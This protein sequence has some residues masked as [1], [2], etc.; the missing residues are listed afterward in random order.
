VS[1]KKT[2]GVFNDV[3]CGEVQE[4]VRDGGILEETISPV[5]VPLGSEQN[6]AEQDILR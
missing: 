3:V 5:R 2:H 1:T 4:A 6:K